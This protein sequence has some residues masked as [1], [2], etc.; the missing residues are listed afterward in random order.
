ML[1][2]PIIGGSSPQTLLELPGSLFH[3]DI[4]VHAA[5]GWPAMVVVQKDFEDRDQHRRLF[6]RVYS[7]S[8][9][10]WGPAQQINL[11]PSDEGNGNYGGAAIGI[12]GNGTVHVA[13]GGAFTPNQP[14]YY[15]ASSDYG[16]TWSPPKVVANGCYNV[17][18]LV[19]T[20]D[21]RV[22]ILA[23]CGGAG[24]ALQPGIMVQRP[25]GTWLP[26]DVLGVNGR[27][28][29]MVVVGDGK[30]SQLVGLVTAAGDSRNGTVF[31]RRIDSQEAWTTTP[32]NLT[33]PASDPQASNYLF[34]GLAFRRPNST[35]GVIFTW[36]MYP[37]N[38]IYAIT[39]LDSGRSWGPVETIVAYEG[40]PSVG[41]IQALD[42][43]HSAPAYDVQADRLLVVWTG[44]DLATPF[45]QL[46]THYAA[47]SQ[48]A[49]HSWN[50]TTPVG[51]LE[52]LIP[53]ETGAERA[54]FIATAQAG[55]GS[56]LWLAWIE[57]FGRVRVRSLDMN[58]VVPID[59]YTR[60]LG[61]L[62]RGVVPL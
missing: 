60:H 46:G 29:S 13:W 62:L 45:P 15:S 54:S 2:T 26:R 12:S 48:P 7:P 52:Q 58:L 17:Q 43:R 34:R 4:A 57:A 49:S 50:A 56:Y 53:L 10:A 9:E 1:P 11:P 21:N 37:A 40:S 41:T 42:A 36:S 8:G 16:A 38:A 55:N 51:S 61:P 27:W 35:A 47:W 24:G 20:V 18:D 19:A 32:V 6:A 28:G 14:V 39:S 3:V 5:D 23:L 25:D 44:R 30:E 59:E 31:R 22:A 33:S